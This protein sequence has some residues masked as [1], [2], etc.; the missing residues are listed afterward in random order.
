[1]VAELAD[2]VEKVSA[3]Q[4]HECKAAGVTRTKMEDTRGFSEKANVS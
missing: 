2:I 4:E 3:I 1:M